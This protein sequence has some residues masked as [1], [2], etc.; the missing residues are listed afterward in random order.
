MDRILE[1]D[2]IMFVTMKL[3][4]VTSIDYYFK[5]G[6]LN[7]SVFQRLLL[8]FFCLDCKLLCLLREKMV[9]LNGHESETFENF[10]LQ[11]RDCETCEH[12][13]ICSY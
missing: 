13:H 10:I 11:L 7:V 8:Y 3:L 2:N 4:Y 6:H 12:F 9:E 5:G 1:L